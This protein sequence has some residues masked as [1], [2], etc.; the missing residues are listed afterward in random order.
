GAAITFRADVDRLHQARRTDERVMPA[1][2]R[3]GAGVG[4]LSGYRDLIPAHGLHAGDDADVLALGL[5]IGSLLDV[6]FEEGGELVVAAFRRPAIA[7]LVER[8]AEGFA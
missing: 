4:V 2:H 3:R 1:R 6:H 8:R 7:D 5:E